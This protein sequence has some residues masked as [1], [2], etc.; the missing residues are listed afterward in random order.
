V[1][2]RRASSCCK[3]LAGA[4]GVPSD[5]TRTVLAAGGPYIR[6]DVSSLF[7]GTSRNYWHGGGT[8]QLVP[9]YLTTGRLPAGSALL[10]S[11]IGGGGTDIG[12]ALA[13]QYRLDQ[14]IEVVETYG[15]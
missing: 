15:M 1:V 13:L 10:G 3:Q 5:I 12:G 14:R 6:Q 9:S 2:L 11:T 8:S 7:G 4:A